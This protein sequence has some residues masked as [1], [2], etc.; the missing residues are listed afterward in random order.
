VGL[1]SLAIPVDGEPV[2]VIVDSDNYPGAFQLDAAFDPACGNGFVSE[3]AGE[4]CDDGNTEAGDGCS[5]YCTIEYDV[6]CAGA[7][8]LSL[9]TISADNSDA[10]AI[11]NGPA[12]LG[13]EDLYVFTPESDGVLTVILESDADLSLAVTSSCDAYVL[14]YG[15]CLNEQPAGVAEADVM[16]VTAGV[17]LYVRVDG[18]SANDAGSYELALALQ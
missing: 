3:W 1:T 12:C 4:E 13:R 7:M 18:A 6:I 9:G 17:P 5:P 2:Y 15:S 16:V 10:S 14:E 8:E 11:A